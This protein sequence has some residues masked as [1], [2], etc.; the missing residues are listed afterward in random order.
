MSQLSEIRPSA[1]PVQYKG[2]QTVPAELGEKVHKN[3]L[4]K[5]LEEVLYQNN[6]YRTISKCQNPKCNTKNNVLKPS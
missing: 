3:L 5:W 6:F 4:K 2:Y 1:L